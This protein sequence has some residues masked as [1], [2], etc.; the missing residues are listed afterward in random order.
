MRFGNDTSNTQCIGITLVG[1][2]ERE[3]RE[4]FFADVDLDNMGAIRAGNPSRTTI[5]IEGMPQ[6]LS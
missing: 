6:Q 3:E 1:D 4:D 2:N 5:G